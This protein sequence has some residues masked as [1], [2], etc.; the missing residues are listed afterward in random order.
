MP[1]RLAVGEHPVVRRVEQLA[2]SDD[3]TAR[4]WDAGTGKAMTP[5]LAHA[6]NVVHEKELPSTITWRTC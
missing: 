3:D 2:V 4:V 1:I 6:D 5:P